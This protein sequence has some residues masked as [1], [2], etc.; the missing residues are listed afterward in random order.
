M[1]GG[2]KTS[3]EREP[4]PRTTRWVMRRE[5]MSR[6][7]AAMPL[8]LTQSSQRAGSVLSGMTPEN[9]IRHLKCMNTPSWPVLDR[10]GHNKAKAHPVSTPCQHTLSA[11][12]VS[13]TC[14]AP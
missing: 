9:A 7:S 4:G 5:T 6:H 1:H 8:L 11:H 13:T 10:F 2:Y 3:T 12:P 14:R